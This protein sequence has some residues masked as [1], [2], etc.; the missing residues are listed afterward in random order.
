MKLSEQVAALY[1][2]AWVKVWCACQHRLFAIVFQRVS[3]DHYG[4]GV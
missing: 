4:L 1:S 2:G 3:C